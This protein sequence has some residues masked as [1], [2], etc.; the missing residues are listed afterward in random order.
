M[1][2]PLPRADLSKL[3]ASPRLCF[4][5][6]F[7]IALAF[8]LF[9]IVRLSAPPD[10]LTLLHSDAK[11]YWDWATHLREHGPLG[12]NPFFMAPLYPYLLYVLRSLLGD[13]VLP[14]IV[15]QAFCGS[16][17]VAVLAHTLRSLVHPT[18]ALLIGVLFAGNTTAILMDLLLLT[19][20]ILL[21]LESLFLFLVIRTEW[22]RVS[23]VRL[24]A[25]GL[26]VGLMALA[27]ATSLLLL[28]VP[29]YAIVRAQPWWVSRLRSAALLVSCVLLTSLLVLWRH[30]HLT[31]EWIPYTYNFG[32]NFYMGNGPSAQGTYAPAT[33]GVDQLPLGHPIADGGVEGDGR[34]YLQVRYGVRLS[35]SESSAFWSSMAWSAIR[36]DPLRY[37]TLLGRKAL[38]L[39]N[40]REFPQLFSPALYRSAAIIGWPLL[41]AFAFLAPFGV[42][43]MV[44][45]WRAGVRGRLP[46]LFVLAISIGTLPFFVV[47][48]Y[49]V[50]LLPG[51]VLLAGLGISYLCAQPLRLQR[52]LLLIPGTLLVSAPLPFPRE[53]A[54]DAYD[55][56]AGYSDAWIRR[57]HPQPALPFY[58]EALRILDTGSVS[59]VQSEAGKGSR[60]ALHVGY[61]EALRQVGNL[62]RSI[63]EAERALTF[64]PYSAAIVDYVAS[65]HALAGNSSR[66][67]ALMAS[68][69]CDSTC[70]SATMLRKSKQL[71]SS[72]DTTGAIQL[73]LLAGQLDVRNDLAWIAVVRL[74]ITR[75]ELDRASATLREARKVGIAMPI[76]WAHQSLISLLAGD[77]TTARSALSR[78]R[79]PE[80]ADPRI[81]DLIHYLRA[82]LSP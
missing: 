64:A 31:G 13:S 21:L 71:A 59:G 28:A 24:A 65:L 82:T 45:S 42:A 66:T 67:V 3:A 50:H 73:L 61:S 70:A 14:I 69:G 39:W 58:A 47:D 12:T 60:A 23:R 20:S 37:L 30:H 62:G 78:I 15:V 72:G 16:F 79:P 2:L 43:G 80:A 77:I 76:Y 55:V 26:I 48:R 46:L 5:A 68:I 49:R 35:P 6:I 18:L 25:V 10:F 53:P 34:H 54:R 33:E 41:G 52:W 29:L 8:R 7:L 44:P 74:M 63:H 38:M 36:D 75:G 9:A 17:T 19:E 1:P 57:G 22:G 56:A 4:L 51:V 32:L 11:T 81:R 27:R 40:W